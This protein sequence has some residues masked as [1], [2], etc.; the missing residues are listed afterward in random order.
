MGVL[1]MSDIGD[2]LIRGALEALD[3]AQGKKVDIKQGSYSRCR[4]PGDIT[5]INRCPILNNTGKSQN[6]HDIS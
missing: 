5:V 6:N 4:F 2:S 3:Y 1:V